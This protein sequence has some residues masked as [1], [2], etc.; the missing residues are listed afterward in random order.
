MG[1]CL[2]DDHITKDHITTQR[3][4]TLRKPQQKY[5]LGPVSNRCL[6]VGA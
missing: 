6:G 3:H 5:S 1:S 4:V 2:L